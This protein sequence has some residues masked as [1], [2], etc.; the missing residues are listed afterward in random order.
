MNTYHAAHWSDPSYS[1]S[2]EEE[3][4]NTG[5]KVIG[6]QSNHMAISPLVIEVKAGTVAK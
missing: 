5:V 1:S 4:S 3:N 2:E 6:R